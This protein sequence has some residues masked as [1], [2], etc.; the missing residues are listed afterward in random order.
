MNSCIVELI[1]R[2]SYIENITSMKIGFKVLDKGAWKSFISG[3]GTSFVM[4]HANN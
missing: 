3:T 1:D 4:A 2:S